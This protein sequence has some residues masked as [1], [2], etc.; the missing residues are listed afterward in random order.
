MKYLLLILIATTSLFATTLEVEKGKQDSINYYL[1]VPQQSLPTENI[2]FQ[3]YSVERN[4]WN[5]YDGKVIIHSDTFYINQ[6]KIENAASDTLFSKNLVDKKDQFFFCEA[7]DSSNNTKYT[8]NYCYLQGTKG[9]YLKSMLSVRYT[10]DSTKLELL[11]DTL[12]DSTFTV[13]WYLYNWYGYPPNYGEQTIKL[14]MNKPSITASYIDTNEI[15][16]YH[17]PAG[18]SQ[19]VYCEIECNSGDFEGFTYKTEEVKASRLL[20]NEIIAIYNPVEISGASPI[21][22]SNSN[23]LFHNNEDYSINIYSARGQLLRNCTSKKLCFSLKDLALAS[24]LYQV[25]VIQG[26]TIF[27]SQFILR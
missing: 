10:D 24:G 22:I 23:I 8:S 15:K 12:L 3:W 16:Y 9:E 6:L 18:G 2:R 1:Y 20:K 19:T 5:E 27:R 4:I 25:Q 21:S 13:T 7:V 26:T 14:A 17:D 11:N